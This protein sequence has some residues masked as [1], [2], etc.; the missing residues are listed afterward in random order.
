MSKVLSALVVLGA[1]ASL[2][3]QSVVAYSADRPSADRAE[4]SDVRS[5]RTETGLVVHEQQVGQ[6]LIRTFGEQRGVARVKLSEPKSSLVSWA[7]PPASERAK[8]ELE[9]TVYEMSLAAGMSAE[10]ACEFAEGMDPYGCRTSDQV[11]RD[12]VLDDGG[13]IAALADRPSAAVAV[14]RAPNFLDSD[15]FDHVT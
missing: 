11:S 9:P 6:T 4:R 12:Q 15:C 13:E 5:Y 10:D 1:T 14:A 7:P 2:A 3:A 8:A